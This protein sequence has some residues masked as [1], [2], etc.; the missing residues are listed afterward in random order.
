MLNKVKQ[1]F[2][3]EGVKVE[4]L[5]PETANIK[6]GEIKGQLKFSSLNPQNVNNINLKLIEI[7]TRGRGKNKVTN[8]YLIGKKEIKKSF[9]VPSDTFIFLDFK[10][11]FELLKSEIDEMGDKNI[12]LGGIAKLAK[13][14]R[15]VTS[16][17]RVEVEVDVKGTGLSP[18]DKK[19]IVLK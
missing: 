18:F 17:F 15:G 3:I 13:L 16:T 9:A 1:W 6:Q 7:Y 4:L 14:S 5:I 2:G 19:T 10:L 8:E 11:P 12:L